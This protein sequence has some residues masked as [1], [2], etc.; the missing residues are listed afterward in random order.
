MRRSADACRACSSGL[1]RGIAPRS[2][3]LGGWVRNN[4]DGTVEAAFEGERDKVESMVEWCRRGPAHAEVDD[5]EVVWEKPQDE[6]EFAV[7]GG[8]A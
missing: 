7:R 1:R 8:W 6:E 2:L 4:A 5:I 3:G